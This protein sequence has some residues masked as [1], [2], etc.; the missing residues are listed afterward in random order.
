[1]QNY[2]V[3]SSVAASGDGS[4]SSP[5]KQ[6]SDFFKPRSVSHPITINI[7]KGLTYQGGVIDNN[8]LL[9]NTT[10]AESYIKTYG[11]GSPPVIVARDI[12]N[13]RCIRRPKV[14]NLIADPIILAGT[15]A[16]NPLGNVNPCMIAGYNDT[17]VWL[18]GWDFHAIGGKQQAW[19][20]AFW[21]AASNEVLGNAGYFGMNNPK[22]VDTARGVLVMGINDIPSGIQDNNGD[23]YYVYGI[24]I[25]NPSFVNVG[26]D[27]IIL[28]NAASIDNP[29]N[30]NMDKVIADRNYSGIVNPAYSSSRSDIQNNA[31]VAFWFSNANR[32]FFINRR[33]M[34]VLERVMVL[35]SK[36]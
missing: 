28:S 29:K 32:C 25:N 22:F 4:E 9:Y 31:S 13:E 26:G 7:K 6:L 5:F 24:R 30:H 20:P 15:M 8:K 18:N 10:P 34:A 2:Y 3:D 27:G 35:I 17:N 14:R 36:Q 23:R 1:M 33:S 16:L 12:Y 21:F 19:N 11:E